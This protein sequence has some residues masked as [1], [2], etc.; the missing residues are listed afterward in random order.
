MSS[1]G[2]NSAHGPAAVE[3]GGRPRP[4]PN[5]RRDKP[6]LSCNLCRRRKYAWPIPSV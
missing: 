6:Q 3:S 5:R 4:P 2:D 1:S